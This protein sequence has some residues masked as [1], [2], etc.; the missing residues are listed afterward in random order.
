MPLASD[1]G[2][3]TVYSKVKQALGGWRY[4]N[5]LSTVVPVECDGVRTSKPTDLPCI[6]EF[7]SEESFQRFTDSIRSIL[8]TLEV[9]RPSTQQTSQVSAH[10]HLPI[11][12]K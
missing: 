7:P 1:Y 2:S 5:P 12:T 11:D 10:F 3:D 9:E 6:A 8:D 4:D